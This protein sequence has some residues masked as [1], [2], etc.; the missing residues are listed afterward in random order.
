MTSKKETFS[1]LLESF[2]Y[3]FDLRTVFDDFLTMSLCAVTRNPKTGLSHYE[4]LYLE[5]IKY[6]AKD[7]LRFQ[8]PE[9]LDAL[10]NEMGEGL[11]GSECSDILGSYYEQQCAKNGLS[12]FFTPWPICEFMA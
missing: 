1:T 3:R 6:Y 12:Q 7:E 4:D 9:M 10:I 5:T 11:N 2:M 8:F